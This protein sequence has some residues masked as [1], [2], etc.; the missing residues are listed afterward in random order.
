[1]DELD[2]FV[3]IG[4]MFY[5]GEKSPVSGMYRFMFHADTSRCFNRHA[6]MTINDVAQRSNDATM[7]RNVAA[8]RQRTVRTSRTVLFG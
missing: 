6:Q 1:M 2:T 5:T 8:L 7:A 4:T 3:T